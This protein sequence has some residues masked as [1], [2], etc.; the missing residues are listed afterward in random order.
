MFHA[1]LYFYST[2]FQREVGKYR[3]VL[4]TL[5]IYISAHKTRKE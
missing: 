3:A 2:E 1:T 5:Q 4:V